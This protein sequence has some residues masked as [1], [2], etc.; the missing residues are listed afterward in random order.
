[1]I[2]ILLVSL[3]VLVLSGCTVMNN[4]LSINGD[5]I[6][7]LVMDERIN[8]EWQSAITGRKVIDINDEEC[9]LY[10]DNNP[11]QCK[12]TLYT[13]DIF[14]VSDMKNTY[15]FGFDFVDDD[16]AFLYIRNKQINIVIPINRNVDLN[17]Q[18]M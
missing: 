12:M 2:R 3:T 10:I 6:I 7:F 17:L 13:G 5:E 18:S 4:K 11:V 1:M 15:V 8:G 14:Y 9:I 16:K